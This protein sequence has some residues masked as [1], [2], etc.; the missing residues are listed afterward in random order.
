MTPLGKHVDKSIKALTAAA[1]RAALDD[2]QL[3]IAEVEAAWFCNTRQGALEGQHGI[4]GQAALRAFGF[5]G[6]PIFNTDNACASSSSGVFQAYAAVKAGLVDI[7]LVVGAEK[8]V[9]PE[10]RREM[11]EAFKGSW[12]REL[13]DQHMKV[14]LSLGDGVPVSPEAEA[15]ASPERS[16]FMDIYAAQARFHMQTFGT[17]ERQ[18]AA[19]AAKN[20]TH[21]QH[22]PYA[23]YR[24]PLTVEDVLADRLVV[25]PITRAMCAPIS[26]GACALLLGSETAVR[27]L[28]RGQRAVKIRG[29]GVSSSSNRDPK[30][31][32]RHLTRVAAQRAYEQASVGP[33]DIS[34]AELHDATAFAEILHCENVG[35][36]AYGE[37]GPLAESGATNLGGR[38]P[39][40]VSGGLLSKGHPIGATGAIQL[41]ELVTQLR[42]EAGARQV[43]GAS[44][45][46]AENGG[47]FHGVEEAACVVTILEK[48]V[49]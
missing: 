5:E 33:R 26:D 21:S 20:H 38:L 8:M 41:F 24:F 43:E 16:V 36:C 3:E 12:D 11:F 15:D 28:G 19:V 46:L 27:R 18:I 31:Y 13:A 29:I 30:A 49:V 23:Q 47:G 37:G 7:A 10:K 39:I 44:L 48:P 35:F 17:T 6:I 9:Y 32:D 14:L 25:W 2:A 42:G 45:A 34:V 4:R 1:V 40:N 22:N